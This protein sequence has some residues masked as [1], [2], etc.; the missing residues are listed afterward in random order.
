[1]NTIAWAYH[2]VSIAAEQNLVGASRELMIKFER[3]KNG[4]ELR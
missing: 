3:K 4:G 2:P 1:M